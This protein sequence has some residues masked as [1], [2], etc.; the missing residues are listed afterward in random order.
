MDFRLE[1]KMKRVKSKEEFKCGASLMSQ[2]RTQG[3]LKYWR[4]VRRIGLDWNGSAATV[5]RLSLLGADRAVG[6]SS[7]RTGALAVDDE[8]LGQR[9]GIVLPMNMYEE[10]EVGEADERDAAGVS[11]TIC[12]VCK[13]G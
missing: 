4:S 11:D 12:H 7:I 1:V 3:G 5:Q 10:D 2:A 6:A 9:P 13:C 8:P